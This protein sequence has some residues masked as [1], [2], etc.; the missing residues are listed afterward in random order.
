MPGPGRNQLCPC[1]SGRK[2]KHC[3]GQARGPSEDQLA[4]AHLAALSRDALD[5]LVGVSDAAL[6]RLDERLFDLPIR[7]LSLQAALPAPAGP[8]LQRLQHAIAED[9]SE[10]GWGEWVAVTE[11]IDTPRERARLADALIALR[12]RGAVT[13]AEAA[14]GIYDLSSPSRYLLMASVIHAVAV[15]VGAE[16]TP[17]GLEV[18]A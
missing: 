8:E 12:D 17:G 9:E 18:A 15:S 4:E 1:G 7:D 2:V 3:C 14:H 16:T 13:V 10:I 6:E 11:Q 5:D